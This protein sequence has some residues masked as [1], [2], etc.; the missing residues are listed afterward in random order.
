MP[1]PDTGNQE[2]PET[3]TLAKNPASSARTGP[4]VDPMQVARIIAASFEQT[5]TISSG[6]LPHPD[7]LA[8][9]EAIFPGAAKRI[10][11]MAEQ[12][13]QHRQR[14]EADHLRN[15]TVRAY[16]GIAAGVIVSLAFGVF[17]MVVA[18]FGHAGAGAT[19]STATVIGLASTFVY[20]SIIRKNE[21]LKKVESM[22]GA[23][24]PM[25]PQITKP[26]QL[27]PPS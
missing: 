5:T 27:D 21:R 19:I 2:K 9:Y 12:Q 25:P 15:D 1:E 10:F 22:V 4:S 23:K 11:V 24:T 6:P 17:G 8:G 26:V 20:G 14:M 7:I 3:Q 18:L 13:S 16:L